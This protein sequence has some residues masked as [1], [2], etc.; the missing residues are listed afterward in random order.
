MEKK[1][2]SQRKCSAPDERRSQ[3]EV[4]LDPSFFAHGCICTHGLVYRGCFVAPKP[5][6]SSV[7][8]KNKMDR[9]TRERARSMVPLSLRANIIK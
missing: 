3:A 2:V 4:D 1:K 7:A 6:L 8:K 9:Y 5:A